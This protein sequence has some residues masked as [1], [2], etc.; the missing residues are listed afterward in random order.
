MVK[1]WRVN[2][3]FVRVV[4]VLA[5]LG[6]SELAAAQG[7]NAKAAPGSPTAD[8]LPIYVAG[9]DV[10]AD[11]AQRLDLGRHPG[12]VRRRQRPPVGDPHAVEP[13]AAGDRRRHVAADRRLLQ[14]GPAGARTRRRG[15]G[16]ARLG[17]AG[18][19]LHLVRPGAWHLPRPQR[20]RVDGHQQRHARDEVHT[21][22]Q[23][24]ADHRRARREQGQQRPRS[25]RRAG[26]LLRRAEDQR[27]VHRRR[28]HQQARRRVRRRHRQVPAPLGRLRQTA[29]RH[30]EVSVPG[31]GGDA[32]AAGTRRCTAS[33]APRTG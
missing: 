15:Q 12:A 4:A 25:S 16:A 17:R 14:A 28:L 20:L 3:I 26:Q 22:R 19:G 2:T 23:A 9:S 10:A 30:R 1:L 8:A 24:R 31:Q 5:L 6:L 7:A 32:A 29:G 18:R 33:S 11:A 21:G 27:A 13:H